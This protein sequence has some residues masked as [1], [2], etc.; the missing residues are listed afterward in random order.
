MSAPAHTRSPLGDPLA[1]V[2]RLLAAL[3]RALPFLGPAVAL[4]LGLAALG[5]RSLD[6]DEAAAAASARGAFGDVVE[7]ALSDEP[8]RAGYLA[9][10]QPVV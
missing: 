10:L 3:D 1:A 8:A 2:A 9:L 5:R 6:V 4:V 7:R